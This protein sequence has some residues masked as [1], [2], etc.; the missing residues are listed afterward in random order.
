MIQKPQS[1]PSIEARAKMK[2]EMG[3]DERGE[4]MD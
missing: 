4:K 2:Q 1:H 3:A